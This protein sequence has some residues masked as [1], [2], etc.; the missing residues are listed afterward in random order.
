MA[1][2]PI[3]QNLPSR[4]ARKARQ[5]V[6]T[7][8]FGN[9]GNATEVAPPNVSYRLPEVDAM[10]PKWELIT[11]CIAGQDA[12]KQRGT[13]YLP[14]PNA[15]DVSPENDA[16]YVGYVTRA[17]FYNVTANTLSGLVGQVFNS[18][19]VSEYPEDLEPL[20]YDCNGRGVTLIQQAK[21]ALSSVLAFGR[22]GLLVDFPP[23]V[24]DEVGNSRAFT[25]QEVMDGRARPTIQ[26]YGPTDIINWRYTQQGAVSVL[27]LVVLVEDYVI[28]D[29]GF[30]IQR[31]NQCRVLRLNGGVYTIETWQRTDDKQEGPYQLIDTV[32][33]TAS[34]GKPFGYIPFYW[35]GSQNNDAQIDK[36]PMYDIANLNIGH[37]RNSADYEDAVFMLGQPTPYFAG[38]SQDWVDNVLKGVIQ[39]G[40]RGAVPLPENGSAGLLQVSE[41]TMVK[42]AMDKKEQQMVALGAQLVE[43]KQ[44]QR[45]L[46][47]A[48]MENAVIAS[49]LTSCAR[50][51]SQAFESALMAAAQFSGAQVNADN[52]KFQL[53]TDF[54]IAK[55]SAQDRQQL[56]QEWQ[57]GGI[58][59]GEYR[60]QLRQSGIATEDDAK[61]KSEIEKDMESAVDLDQ[62]DPANNQDDVPTGE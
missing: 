45:T 36:P 50:N 34:D 22:C 21:K 40:S 15:T 14:K 43:D 58:T 19:P 49:T 18:D 27:S 32:T 30:E 44:V 26:Y 33:P 24:K 7:P 46:G 17:V 56:L 3:N 10:L 41:N 29:D 42:E 48:K 55:M 28:K 13:K 2:S 8:G 61:A 4:A 47:E 62:E 6:Q 16:R 59:W 39:L 57:G 20:W 54:A 1:T 52:L 38:L 23:G 12:I 5:K 60:N 53:S 37:Y 11:D 9:N 51:T 31:G 35:V 25:R